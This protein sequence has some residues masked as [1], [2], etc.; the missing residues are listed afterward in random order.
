M[1]SLWIGG[2]P[3]PASRPRVGKFGTHYSKTYQ[4]WMKDSWVYVKD[5]DQVPTDRPI[6]LVVEAIFAKAKTSKLSHPHPDVDNLAKGP[7][8]QITKL[9]ESG[10]GIWDDDKRVVSLTV[11]KRFALPGEEPGF[12]VM[13]TELPDD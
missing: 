6:I 13:Y 1:L 3:V 7:M 9:T 8:D 11:V 12:R 4:K 2:K 5:L 10:C